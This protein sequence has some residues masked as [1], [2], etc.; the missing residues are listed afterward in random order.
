MV[1]NDEI[2]GKFEIT[3]P[4]IIKLIKCSAM[5]RL[6]KISQYGYVG[7]YLPKVDNNRFK[8]SMGVFCLLRKYGVPIEEQISG[9]LHDVSH[10]AFSHCIDYVLKKKD[11]EKQ[12][13]QD[14]IFDA[15]I[16]KTEIPQILKKFGIKLNYILDD[17]NFLLKENDLPDICAD[18]IDY[19]L[20][21]SKCFGVIDKNKINYF[22]ENLETKNGEWFFRNHQS[23]KTFAKLFYDVNNKYYAGLSTALMFK[24]VGN[25]LK[26]ALD[27]GYID[28]N[29]L[30]TT[31]EEVL[32][33]LRKNLKKD[34][35]LDLFWRKMN[36]KIKYKLGS[37]IKISCKSRAVDPFFMKNGKLIRFSSVDKDWKGI[38]KKESKPKEYF[39]KFEE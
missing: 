2:Y 28:K 35:R 34:K 25:C 37:G 23:V 4:V 5:Q 8:H 27:K 13:Y 21:D 20:R 10:S 7:S 26:Y 31:D 6:K 36:K 22:L 3:E 38:V 16:R 32:K 39:I 11:A 18:R 29:D 15:Y 19:L 30:Y 9:L 12:N 14:D 24:T 17:K 33:E 1:Y